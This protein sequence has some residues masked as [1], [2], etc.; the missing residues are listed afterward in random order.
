MTTL[1]N[2]YTRCSVSTSGLLAPLQSPAFPDLEQQK[3]PLG[4]SARHGGPCL[5]SAEHHSSCCLDLLVLNGE[6]SYALSL[7]MAIGFAGYQVLVSVKRRGL[8]SGV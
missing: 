3:N 5:F 1:D 4:Y 2:R 6:F 8:H 7:G